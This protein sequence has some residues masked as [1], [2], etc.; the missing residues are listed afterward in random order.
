MCLNVKRIGQTNNGFLTKCS[1]CKLYHLTYNNILFEFTLEEFESFKNYLK[2]IEVD[3]WEDKYAKNTIARKIPIHTVQQNLFLMF[4]KNEIESLKKLVL[5]T[6]IN[7]YTIINTTEI[8]YH[9]NLN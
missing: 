1:S 3:Y 6:P 7:N 2:N 5:G 8:D 9:F 4:T